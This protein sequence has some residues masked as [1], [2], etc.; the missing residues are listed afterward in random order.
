MS[1]VA[2]RSPRPEARTGVEHYRDRRVRAEHRGD[3]RGVLERSDHPDLERADRH[4]RQ[5][6]P[7]LFGNPVGTDWLHGPDADRVLRGDRGDHRKRM[8]AHRGERQKVALQSGAAAR[9]GTGERNHDRGERS[10][11]RHVRFARAAVAESCWQR[12]CPHGKIAPHSSP[13]PRLNP[14]FPWR[15]QRRARRPGL[16]DL[17]LHHEESPTTGRGPS[18]GHALRKTCRSTGPARSAVPGRKTSKWW[19]SSV[20]TLPRVISYRGGISYEEARRL[21]LRPRRS[22]VRTR[23]ASLAP[24]LD[25]P[26]MRTPLYIPGDRV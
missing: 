21:D 15:K 17:R 3:R 10:G 26:A 1:P 25:M 9:V 8:T 7:C 22:L 13:I 5:D 24:P 23:G 11:A 2:R 6:E 16:P 19:R 14:L 20:G 18:A 4:V 12:L